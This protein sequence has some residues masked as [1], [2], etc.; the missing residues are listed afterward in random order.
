MPAG[1]V[2]AVVRE[3]DGLD[4]RNAQVGGPGDARGDLGHLDGVR[5]PGAEVIVLGGDEDLALPREPPPFARV[6]D[7]V[8]VALEAQPEGVGILGMGTGAGT[9]RTGRPGREPGRKVGLALLAAQQR[10]AHHRECVGMGVAHGDRGIVGQPE[11]GFGHIVRVP[12]PS[13]T[14]ASDRVG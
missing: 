7:A 2:T 11:E 14:H 10:A 9:R 3:G 8:E 13:D 12:T 6:L 5:E 1:A 4:E